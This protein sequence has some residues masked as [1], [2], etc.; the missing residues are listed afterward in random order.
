MME[1]PS[2]T[3]FPVS[4]F[5]LLSVLISRSWISS[6]QKMEAERFAETL[7]VVLPDYQNRLRHISACVR[8]YI[9]QTD[10]QTVMWYRLVLAKLVASEETLETDFS[11]NLAKTF[12][13]IFNSTFLSPLFV[14][15]RLHNGQ[16]VGWQ[17]KILQ[18]TGDWSVLPIM[19]HGDNS[20]KDR[21][22]ASEMNRQRR[23]E[24]GQILCTGMWLR[25]VRRSVLTS[26]GTFLFS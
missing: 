14:Q 22:S 16:L 13:G 19:S 4:I 9:H 20:D 24:I 3:W 10:R 26:Y 5:I 11:K 1:L 8:V 17:D 21:I 15:S 2:K 7:V 12:L 6:A 23:D 25:V 18:R